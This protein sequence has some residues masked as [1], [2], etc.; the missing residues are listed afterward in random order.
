MSDNPRNSVEAFCEDLAALI[1]GAAHADGSRY[2]VVLAPPGAALEVREAATLAEL[3]QLL[4][5]FVGTDT[6]AH[7]FY[8]ARLRI[9]QVG[10]SL[11]VRHGE[12]VAAIE[13]AGSEQELADGVLRIRSA[14]LQELAEAR[15]RNASR[16]ADAT[17]VESV[18]SADS[19]EG[20]DDAE[21]G[22]PVV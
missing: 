2:Y 21:D 19:D 3:A 14:S 13:V 11:A 8:G 16:P 20:D 7:P 4:G 15:I 18:T 5:E 9:A 22:A 12:R 10:D 1:A 6:V 17:S